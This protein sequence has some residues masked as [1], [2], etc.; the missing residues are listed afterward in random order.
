MFD[1]RHALPASTTNDVGRY[2]AHYRDV[3]RYFDIEFPYPAGTLLIRNFRD[4]TDQGQSLPAVNQHHAAMRHALH[5]FTASPQQPCST[6]PLLHG[7]TAALH[8][9]PY[10]HFRRCMVG[11]RMYNACTYMYALMPWYAEIHTEYTS[12]VHVVLFNRP[13]RTLDI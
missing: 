6:A 1:M 10:L 11:Y 13:R 8:H 4:V 9:F 5:C 2:A 7:S 12:I 3:A